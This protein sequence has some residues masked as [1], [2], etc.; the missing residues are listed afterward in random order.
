MRISDWSSDVCFSDLRRAG[1]L[2]LLAAQVHADG[3][4]HLTAG[5][6]ETQPAREARIED[7]A[8]AL[9]AVQLH[10]ARRRRLQGSQ[11]LRALLLPRQQ[12]RVEQAAA[13]DLLQFR[14][15]VIAIAQHR[16][17]PA[18]RARQA[19]PVILAAADR[20]R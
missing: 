5:Q 18:T 7:R 8:G 20:T 3:G 14:R 9:A 11:A 4:L 6:F 15:E 17:R 1:E 10:A 12:E 19:G 16:L 13:V 2:V